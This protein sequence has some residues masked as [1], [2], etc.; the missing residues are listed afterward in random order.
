MA[1]RVQR[2]RPRI[3]GQKG[4]PPGSKYVGRG[5]RWGNPT[6]VVYD[7]QTGGWHAVHD[8]GSNIGTWPTAAEA[9]RFAVESYR[10]HLDTH[11]DLA[12][13]A[14]TELAGRDLACWCPPP[15]PGEPDY[16][17]GALLLSLAAPTPT[18]PGA[19]ADQPAGDVK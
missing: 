19:D 5:S 11:P 14:R 1:A 12:A 18:S 8:N 9:R 16:C 3:K 6:R 7:R 2:T 4:M 17:H 10:H 15:E 13:A